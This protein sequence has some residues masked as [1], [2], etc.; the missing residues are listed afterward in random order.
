MERLPWEVHEATLGKSGCLHLQGT[1]H[2]HSPPQSF[3]WGIDAISFRDPE[4]AAKEWDFSK[5]KFG[6]GAREVLAKWW[7]TCPA[8]QEIAS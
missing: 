2:H 8:L 3:S 1:N 4:Y 7:P 6:P 5:T